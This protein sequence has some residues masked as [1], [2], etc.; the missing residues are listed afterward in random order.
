MSQTAVM[1]QNYALIIGV[2]EYTDYDPTAD[3]TVP[4]ARNDARAWVRT[5]L[6]IG[7]APEN[8]RV[9]TTPELRPAELGPGTEGVQ[10]GTAKRA[11]IMDG[12]TW[13]SDQIGGDTP[14]TGLITF[15]GHGDEG[16]NGCPVL[17][18]SDL[19]PSLDNV[20]D[21]AKLRSKAPGKVKDNLTVMLDCCHAQVG[22][23]PHDSIRGKLRLKHPV[24]SVLQAVKGRGQMRVVAAC[25][26]DQSSVSSTFS[27]EEMG[28]FTWAS[29]STLGQWKPVV[30]EDVAY[31]GVAYSNLVTRV[32]VLL[33][34]L[35]FE[36]VPV[37]SGPKGVGGEAFLRPVRMAGAG[38]TAVAPTATR[39]GRQL[40]IGSYEL[41]DCNDFL[42]AFIVVNGTASDSI[43]TWY[44]YRNNVNVLL[45]DQNT[46]I[47]L[48][49]TSSSATATPPTGWT[50]RRIMPATVQWV[51][52]ATTNPYYRN[53]CHYLQDSADSNYFQM[54]FQ[55]SDDFT[56]LTHVCFYNT[57]GANWSPVVNTTYRLTRQGRYTSGTSQYFYQARLS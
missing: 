33:G 16:E 39:P 10:L 38:Q 48:K 3:V 14:A 52:G 31:I 47:T 53:Q 41:R 18:P 7:F 11:D 51:G 36:Q 55:F 32:R 26:R 30:E 44:I 54:S 25:M 17:C 5:C 22:T 37:V 20:I 4:G 27:G 24:E 46:Y 12:L 34:A 13:L 42:A 56:D 9:L 21:V 40:D 49:R 19:T 23:S 50:T 43:E 15:S 1:F 2:Q 28:A 29:V 57:T 8:I 6:S 45:S 35:S